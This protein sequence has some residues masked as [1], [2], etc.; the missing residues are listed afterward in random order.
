MKNVVRR[1]ATAEE[2]KS[3]C[4]EWGNLLQSSNLKSVFL[5]WEMLY[6][7]WSHYG[8]GKELWLVEARANGA[9]AGIAPLMLIR[10]KKE[11]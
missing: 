7:W 10:R 3:L 2:F 8:H 9:L 1:I 11:A 6:T 4:N 5:T